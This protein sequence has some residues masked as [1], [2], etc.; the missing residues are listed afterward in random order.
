MTRWIARLG[1]LFLL[2]APA[3][4]QET[5]RASP[6]AMLPGVG[7]ADP[8]SRVDR[9]AAPWRA[10]GRVQTE[11]GGR[12]TGVLIAPDRVLTAAHCLVGPRSERFVQ[13]G[14][15]H[16]L[17][18]YHLGEWVAAARVRSYLRG[19]AYVPMQGPMGA[20]WAILT[21]ERPIGTPDRILPL[22]RE[23]PPPRTPVMLGGYQK[24]RPELLMAD[25]GCRLL[26]RQRHASGFATLV[27]DCAGTS[28]TSGAPLLARGPD[29]GWAVIGVVAAT[30]PDTALG[31]AAPAAAV[32]LPE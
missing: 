19:P 1:L 16:F 20:D 15:V 28:G 29:G 14:S 7:A 9:N 18:G 27:H 13:P 6:G 11:V 10:I 23:A 5:R 32:P 24:D 31:H 25:T 17:L 8:R 30:S 12:C 2:A 3:A 22:L 26:G 4:A 21:L